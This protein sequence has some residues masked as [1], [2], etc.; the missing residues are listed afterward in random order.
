MAVGVVAGDI[1]MIEPEEALETEPF[2][3][4]PR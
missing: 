4:R 2:V 3:N 1:A